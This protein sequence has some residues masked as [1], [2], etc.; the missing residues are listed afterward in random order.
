MMT[1]CSA[2]SATAIDDLGWLSLSRDA[3]GPNTHEQEVTFLGVTPDDF[4][5]HDPDGTDL[6]WMSLEPVRLNGY[7]G[8]DCVPIRRS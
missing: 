2:E 5:A 1:R 4:G 8:D 6:G 3:G 7:K